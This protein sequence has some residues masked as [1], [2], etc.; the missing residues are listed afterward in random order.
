MSEVVDVVTDTER[1]QVL[2]HP[3]RLQLLDALTGPTSAAGL[4]RQLGL[5]RQRINYHL[6]ELETQR[7]VECV[8]ERT[9]G[10]VS[11]RIYRRTGRSYAISIDTL[12]RLGITPENVQDRYSSAF[13]IALAS[14]AIA[15]LAALRAGAAAA[16]QPLAT[17]ALDVE[18]RFADAESRSRFAQDLA[19]AVAA[20]VRRHHD[21]RAPDGRTFRCWLGVHPKPKPPG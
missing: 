19:D 20:L 18:V 2:L 16:G 1:A 17:F 5:P 3:T 10:S 12:G 9:R 13:Q 21:E 7:L 15:E 8:E 14:R 11:E 4:A 6:R